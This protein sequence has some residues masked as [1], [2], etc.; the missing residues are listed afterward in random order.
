MVSS[1]SSDPKVVSSL[2]VAGDARVRSRVLDGI[3]AAEGL[4]VLERIGQNREKVGVGLVANSII[5]DGEDLR[6][7]IRISSSTDIPAGVVGRLDVRLLTSRGL[8]LDELGTLSSSAVADLATRLGPLS[9]RLNWAC[10]HQR[11]WT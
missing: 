1:M 3:E 6:R 7:P 11:A 5:G 10:S 8:E 2:F 4:L 9:S